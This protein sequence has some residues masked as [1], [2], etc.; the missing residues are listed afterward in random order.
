MR[1]NKAIVEMLAAHGA[2]V[3]AA[4]KTYRATA[5][6]LAVRAGH[7]GAV[8][9]LLL[10]KAPV[11]AKDAFGKT[12]LAYAETSGRKDVVQLLREHGTR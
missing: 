6:H 9:A 11:D 4:D 12:P 7:A 5:L 10:A 1:G 3:D 2:R 8:E